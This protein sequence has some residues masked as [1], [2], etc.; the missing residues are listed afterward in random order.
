MRMAP[1]PGAGKI[2]APAASSY[3]GE[4]R[5]GGYSGRGHDHRALL[6]PQASGHYDSGQRAD[7]VRDVVEYCAAHY[8]TLSFGSGETLKLI[9][10]RI[11]GG[12][13]AAGGASLLDESD[14]TAANLN[15]AEKA[16]VTVR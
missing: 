3:A 12:G 8:G 11:A 16:A 5:P 1:K 9:Q 6:W 13:Y 7:A 10:S 2:S 15:R 4:L 14:F